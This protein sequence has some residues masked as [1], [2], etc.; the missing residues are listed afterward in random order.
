MKIAFDQ[1]VFLLQQYGG[2]SRYVCSLAEHLSA[3]GRADTRIVAP[4][5]FNHALKDSPI[6]GRRLW[7]PQL[8]SKAFRLVDA[9]SKFLA[10]VEL[11]QFQPQIMHETYFTEH[12]FRPARAARVLTVYDMIH[13]KYADSFRNAHWTSDA[14]RTAVNRADH[15][16]CI[17]ENTRRDLIELWGIPETKLSVTHLAADRIFEQ[18][19]IEDTDFSHARPYVLIVGSRGNYKNFEGFLRAF[20]SLS[21]IR[22]DVDVICFGGGAIT[23]REQEI[24]SKNGLRL[25]QLVHVSGDDQKLLSLYHGALALVYPSIYEGFGIPPLEAMAAGCPV[26]T[27]NSS[28]LPEVVGDAGEYFAPDDDADMAAA[29]LRV[30][31][32]AERRQELISLG[33]LRH[34]LFSWHKCAKQTLDIYERLI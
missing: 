8:P 14:K 17:S 31:A 15:I 30:L 4:L 32:S 18:A 19:P 9:T 28:S 23:P 3:S 6:P 21:G 16:V 27:S 7:L 1:Q 33:R 13:E 12:S 10:R 11:N 25:E 26:I 2:I 5:H 20:S 22:D 24:A 34:A 29:M